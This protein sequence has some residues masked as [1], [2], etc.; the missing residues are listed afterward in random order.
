MRRTLYRSPGEQGLGLAARGAAQGARRLGRRLPRVR[1]RAALL[2]GRRRPAPAG[3]P[4]VQRRDAGTMPSL[5]RA[6]L[7]RVRGA[8]RGVRR[9]APPR[10]AARGADQKVLISEKRISV[11]RSIS[12]TS[13]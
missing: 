9:G 1:L 5:R 7:V 3:V 8:V 6:V 11:T 4:P 2:R 12:E 10:R 13:R